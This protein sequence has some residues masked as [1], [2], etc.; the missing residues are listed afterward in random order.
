MT[1]RKII[2][3]LASIAGI[4]AGAFVLSGLIAWDWNLANWSIFGRAAFVV[5]ATWLSVIPIMLAH[6]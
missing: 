1:H 2:T 3:I 5:C 4:W 6:D